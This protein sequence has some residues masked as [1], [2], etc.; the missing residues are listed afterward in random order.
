M[1]L[2]MISKQNYDGRRIISRLCV[3]SEVQRNPVM[4]ETLKLFETVRTPVTRANHFCRPSVDTALL[5]GT[6][7]R[8]CE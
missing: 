3:Q 6:R 7:N 4:E 5:R 2:E 1:H 8:I